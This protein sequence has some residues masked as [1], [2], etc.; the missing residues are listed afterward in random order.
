MGKLSKANLF[1]STKEK[2]LYSTIRRDLQ[3][4]TRDSVLKKVS[5]KMQEKMTVFDHL[6]FAMR[7][8][9]PENK[10]G[11]NDSGEPFNIK[12]IEKEVIKFRKRLFKNNNC[13]KDKAYQKMISK[14]DK[15]WKMLFCDPIIVEAKVGK[16]IIQPQ[17]TN[18]ILEQFF[19]I[20][21]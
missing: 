14:I 5:A 1:K 3:V 17:R 21:M 7:I 12:M 6:R 10:R 9:L 8:T 20:L 13:M 2:K 4:V 15:Y 16:I 11:L 18:N 19:R